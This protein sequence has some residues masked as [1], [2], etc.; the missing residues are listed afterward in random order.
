MPAICTA[1][2]AAPAFIAAATDRKVYQTFELA[3]KEVHL[4][5][6]VVHPQG[7]LVGQTVGAVQ[8]ETLTNIV[9]HQGEGGVDI[10]PAHAVTLSAGDT[11]LVIATMARLIALE[12]LNQP[13][14]RNEEAVRAS[15]QP[16]VSP[17]R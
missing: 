6:V 5:D 16:L 1:S 14:G 13:A 11:V 12:L 8:A 9:M 4:T 3:G 10:N 15:V 17:P 2:V 7:A